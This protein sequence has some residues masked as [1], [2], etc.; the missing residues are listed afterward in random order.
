MI[1]AVLKRGIVP[2]AERRGCHDCRMNKAAVSWWCTSEAA[3]ADRGT[4]LPIVGSGCPHWQPCRTEEQL[5]LLERA[6]GDHL[7]IGKR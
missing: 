4:R 7:L 5:G 6:V 1:E 2:D 3:I